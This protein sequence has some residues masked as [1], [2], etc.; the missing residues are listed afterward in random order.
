MP[1]YFMLK[2][3]AAGLFETLV[4]F[5]NITRHLIVE[6]TFPLKV[7]TFFYC[8]KIKNNTELKL[9][10]FTNLTQFKMSVIY[11]FKLWILNTLKYTVD[12]GIDIN[13]Y[14]N[15]I[16]FHITSLFGITAECLYV[17]SRVR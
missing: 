9:N 2:I 17:I 15:F 10:L 7:F 16:N 13:Y 5:C 11:L 1:L 3:E 14:F 12:F 6:E 8:D 4:K